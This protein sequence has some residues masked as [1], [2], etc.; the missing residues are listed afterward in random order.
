MLLKNSKAQ[1]VIFAKFLALKENSQITF[2]G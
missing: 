2:E 1:Y